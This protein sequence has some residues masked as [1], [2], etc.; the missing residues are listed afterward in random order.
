MANHGRIFR[1]DHGTKFSHCDQQQCCQEDTRIGEYLWCRAQVDQHFITEDQ[2]KKDTY[3][4]NTIFTTTSIAT[5]SFFHLILWTS[6]TNQRR[7]KEE[8]LKNS[9]YRH[10]HFHLILLS[11]ESQGRKKK[12]DNCIKSY[13]ATI[14]IFSSKN[15]INFWSIY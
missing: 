13:F 14:I 12:D 11:D 15:N 7:K 2:I 8:K 1:N 10:Q 4:I 5:F 3:W 6:T 9:W